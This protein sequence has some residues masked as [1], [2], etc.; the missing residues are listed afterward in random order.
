MACHGGPN[1]VEDNL[2][3]YLDAAN[4]K[5]YPGTGDT[6]SDLSGNGNN[7][8]LSGASFSSDNGGCITFDGSNDYGYISTLDVPNR[9]FTASVWI[10][11]ETSLDLWQS[12]I[13]QDSSDSGSHGAMYFQKRSHNQS[14]N[15]AFSMAIRPDD[16]DSTTSSRVNSS[17]IA[18]LN[19]WT[20]VCGAVSSSDIKIYINGELD[21]T[22]S[23][24]STMA[25]R[26]GNF[27]IGAAYWNDNIVDYFKGKMSTVM[28]YSNALS[29]T[30]I[31]Q[32]FNALK[33]RYGL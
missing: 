25:P 31:A 28:V 27:V 32:N 17:T 19:I 29:A 5:S 13:G 8:T 21:G 33:R 11:H 22:I 20:N 15:N 30:E 23:N 12:Y 3:L 24:S 2:V 18:S 4:T 14:P 7:A 1:L 9:P 6:W 10:K 26:T 16:S